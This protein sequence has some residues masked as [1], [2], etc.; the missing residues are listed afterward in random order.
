MV[1]PWID[2]ANPSA[3]KSNLSAVLFNTTNTRVVM[4]KLTQEELNKAIAKYKKQHPRVVEMRL[5]GDNSPLEK[6]KTEQ[7]GLD[8]IETLEQKV[9]E[10]QNSKNL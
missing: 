7:L 10:L 9:K 2:F 8:I 4:T 1:F 3:L 5:N 6:F